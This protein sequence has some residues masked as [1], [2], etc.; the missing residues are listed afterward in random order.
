V[1]GALFAVWQRRD[2]IADCG[3][4]EQLLSVADV[5]TRE[6]QGFFIRLM[7]VRHQPFDP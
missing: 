5:S 1:T 2:A 7:Q 4:S 6:Q 3:V